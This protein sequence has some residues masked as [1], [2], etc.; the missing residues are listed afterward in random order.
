MIVSDQPAA[1]IPESRR[2]APIVLEPHDTVRVAVGRIV[3]TIHDHLAANLPVAI[4]GRND[5]GVHQVRVALRRFRALAGLLRHDNPNV[6]LDVA[7]A[8]ARSLAGT[9]GDARNWDVFLLTTLPHLSALAR[10]DI[11][12]AG[13]LAPRARPLRHAAYGQVRRALGGAHARQL[14]RLLGQMTDGAVWMAP[15]PAAAQETLDEPAVDFAARH[16]TRL[17]RKALRAGRDFALLTP[18]ARHEVRLVLKK[19]R[20][21]AEFFSALHAPGGK[22]GPYIRHLSALQDVL[23]MDSDVLTT[24]TLLTQLGAARAVGPRGAGDG[25]SRDA[26]QRTLGAA[27]GFLCCR[28]LGVHQQAHKKWRKFRRYPVFWQA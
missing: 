26:L 15:L 4:D 3:A 25:D 19:L 22:V 8:H 11:D 23:G 17:H 27:V 12:V 18:P 20:Y 24:R 5:E 28:Q 14:L 10:M 2:S 6:V 7:S 21:S 16:L 1:A 9:M 13:I